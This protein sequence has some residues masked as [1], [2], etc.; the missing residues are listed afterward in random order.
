M[1]EH[2]ANQWNILRC[3]I[4]FALIAKR[5]GWNNIIWSIATT[6]THRG[7]MI[8]GKLQRFLTAIGA[9]VVVR[10]LYR[11]PLRKGQSCRQVPLASISC[12][13]GLTTKFTGTVW[14]RFSPF[15]CLYPF[16]HRV[17]NISLVLIGQYSSTVTKIKGFPFR[18][19][20]GTIFRV[21]RPMFFGPFMNVAG[22]TKAPSNNLSATMTLKTVL[23]NFRLP[24]VD[25]S[26]HKNT[27]LGGFTI[28]QNDETA[29]GRLVSIIAQKEG[30]LSQS[31]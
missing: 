28:R 8:L 18:F 11:P 12:L 25:T 14:M 7:Y 3:S 21:I 20:C 29:V 22:S 26:G 30:V 19:P 6:F 5:A 2:Q 31:V 4:T 16:R 24:R 13:S 27:V 17:C 9:A 1:L 15:V 23:N 10:C